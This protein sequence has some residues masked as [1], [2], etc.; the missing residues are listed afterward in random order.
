MVHNLMLIPLILGGFQDQV[1]CKQVRDQNSSGPGLILNYDTFRDN[2]G[3][4]C[5]NEVN[6]QNLRGFN[7]SQSN[8]NTVV[9]IDPNYQPVL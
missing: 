3:R 1:C 8:M 5:Y 6:D 4:S 2:N 9:V 7:I